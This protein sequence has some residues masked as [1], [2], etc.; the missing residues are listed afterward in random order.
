MTTN[1]VSN[2]NLK[3]NSIT[4]KVYATASDAA[5]TSATPI[6]TVKNTETSWPVS[7]SK[8]ITF[9]RPDGAD[10][11]GRYYRIEFNLTNSNSSKNYGVDLKKMEFYN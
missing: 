3:V 2:S 6:S 4:L 8:V 9:N 10:W 5:S 1:G 11:T 7:S